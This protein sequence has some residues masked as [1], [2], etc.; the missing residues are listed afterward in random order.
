MR[1]EEWSSFAK[2]M[3]CAGKGDRNGEGAEGQVDAR[4]K[5]RAKR[6]E[7]SKSKTVRGYC[8]KSG[9]RPVHLLVAVGNP[10]NV[11]YSEG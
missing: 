10:E 5:G 7:R 3:G 2:L 11:Q 4:G 9:G 8:W 1:V 6:Q